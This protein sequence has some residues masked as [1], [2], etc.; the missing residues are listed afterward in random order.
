MDTKLH[1]F[2]TLC[3]TMNSSDCSRLSTERVTFLDDI[4]CKVKKQVF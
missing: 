4:V 2:L 3:Q 1:T